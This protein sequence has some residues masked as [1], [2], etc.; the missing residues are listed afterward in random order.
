LNHFEQH[1]GLISSKD[2]TRPNHADAAAA[3]AAAAAACAL[4]LLLP[5]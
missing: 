4:L 2:V 3:A 5:Q 1:L